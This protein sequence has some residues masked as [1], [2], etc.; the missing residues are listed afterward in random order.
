MRRTV[1]PRNIEGLHR[2]AERDALASPNA[3]LGL[4]QYQEFWMHILSLVM[5]QPRVEPSDIARPW[6][7]Y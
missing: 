5:L 6:A 2:S 4:P 7:V 1:T 3:D